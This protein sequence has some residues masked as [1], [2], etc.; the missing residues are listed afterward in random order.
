[1]S[2]KVIQPGLSTTIQD[3]GREG[4]YHLGIPPSG[5]MD[6]YAMKAANLLVGNPENTAVLE[7]A[8]L[9]PELEFDTDSLIAVTGAYMSPVLDGD[10]MPL[11]TSLAVKAGQKLSFSYPRKGARAYLAI[12]G[13]LDLPDAL[14]SL[15]TYVLGSLGGIEGRTLQA[16]DVLATGT[17]QQ[18][19]A[20]DRTIPQTLL[21][22]IDKEVTLRFVPGLYNHR[23][24]T[25]SMT[26]FCRDEWTVASEADRIGYRFKNGDPLDFKSRVQPFG[27]GSDP[28]NIVDACYPIGSIQVPAGKEPIVLLRDAVS[29]GGYAMIGTVISTDL[30]RIGQMQPNYK[31]K[32]EPVTVQQALEVRQHAGRRLKKLRAYLG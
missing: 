12:A 27:A 29:G 26:Q 14:G 8:L 10:T 23:I 7:C 2:I 22:P 13:G 24:T 30:D 31:A 32:F 20:P 9:G 25:E 11:N 4:F 16:G 21:Q 15:S 19:A 18:Q 6:Q 28:S 17:P 1:M 5:A 3:G